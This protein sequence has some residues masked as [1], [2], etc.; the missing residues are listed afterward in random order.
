MN[1]A[2]GWGARA[3][4]ATGQV[5]LPPHSPAPNRLQFTACSSHLATPPRTL[6]AQL[7]DA[8]RHLGQVLQGAGW[9]AGAGPMVAQQAP[10]ACACGPLHALTPV[11]VAEQHNL[12]PSLEPLHPSHP[13][14]AL[15][16][17]AN[18]FTCS[19]CRV[20]RWQN[21]TISTGMASLEPPRPDTSLE[22]STMHTNLADAIST[23]WLG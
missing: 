8:A 12:H 10:A 3:R 14:T 20:Y 11:E 17:P 23:I 7:G 16:A 4:A 15:P 6:H 21:C 13:G 22:S 2:A 9:G 19:R 5:T 1:D 18:A